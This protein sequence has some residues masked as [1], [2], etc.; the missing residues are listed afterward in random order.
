MVILLKPTGA[1]KVPGA[2]NVSLPAGIPPPPN[3]PIFEVP[4]AII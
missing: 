1:E 4:I 3:T 2:L